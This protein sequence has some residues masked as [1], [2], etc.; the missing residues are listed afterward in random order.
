[1][2]VLAPAAKSDLCTYVLDVLHNPCTT[3]KPTSSNINIYYEGMCELYA[4]TI[5]SSIYKNKFSFSFQLC[6]LLL[7]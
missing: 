3:I 7:I 4:G 1:M 2:I 5:L 6:V